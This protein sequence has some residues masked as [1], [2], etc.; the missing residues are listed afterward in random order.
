MFTP[1][2]GYVLLFVSNPQ[3]SGEFYQDL[4]GIKP[5]QDFPTFVMFA[6]ENGVKLGLWSKYTAQPRV[7]SPA[8]ALE[9]CFAAQD[10]DAVYQLWDG[11]QVTMAQEPTDMDFGRTF[12]ALDPD[13]HRIRIFK[14]REKK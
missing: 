6:L 14:L 4:F 2:L 8:G 13:G 11:K 9:I 12:V 1:S 7:E 5:I 10:V 3:K